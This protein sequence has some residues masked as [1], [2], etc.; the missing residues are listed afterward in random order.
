MFDGFL[1]H[2]P[3]LVPGAPALVDNPGKMSSE[4]SVAQR[5]ATQRY[6]LESNLRGS[7]SVAFASLLGTCLDSNVVR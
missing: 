3:N 5:T 1:V 4:G 6:L 2:L 7:A